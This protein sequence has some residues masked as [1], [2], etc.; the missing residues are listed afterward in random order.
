M[1]M[2]KGGGVCYVGA[3][4]L[5]GASRE[6]RIIQRLLGTS[7]EVRGS[8]KLLRICQPSCCEIGR[9]KRAGRMCWG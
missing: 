3:A 5:V 9:A 4:L 2:T 8:W 6:S 7:M 1:L